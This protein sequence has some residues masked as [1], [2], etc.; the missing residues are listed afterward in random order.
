MTK[1]VEDLFLLFLYP[2]QSWFSTFFFT[3]Y[4]VLGAS[5]RTQKKLSEEMKLKKINSQFNFSCQALLMI[6]RA[7]EKTR[8]NEND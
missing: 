6:H 7:K 2:T 8:S 4:S 1:E 3:L 5:V